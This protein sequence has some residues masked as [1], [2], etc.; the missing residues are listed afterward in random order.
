MLTS[1]DYVTV[2]EAIC[3]VSECES[4]PLNKFD[5]C[6]ASEIRTAFNLLETINEWDL[7][8][9]VVKGICRDCEHYS[10]FDRRCTRFNASTY[11]SFFCKNWEEKESNLRV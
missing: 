7:T 11:D 6:T 9:P 3:S 4:C 8:H 10:E 1:R 2:R 5:K